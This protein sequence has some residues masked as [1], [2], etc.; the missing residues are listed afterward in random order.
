MAIDLA[1]IDR[2]LKTD[3]AIIKPDLFANAVSDPAIN[4]AHRTIAIFWKDAI[5]VV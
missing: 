4:K 1:A 3:D 5:A 2:N